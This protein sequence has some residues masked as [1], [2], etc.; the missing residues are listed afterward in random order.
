MPVP[1]SNISPPEG[2]SSYSLLTIPA[3]CSD[4]PPKLNQL[5]AFATPASFPISEELDTDSSPNA[6]PSGACS[7]KLPLRFLEHHPHQ[8]H[9][10]QPA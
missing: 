7:A 5:K 8:H 2:V 9:R 4:P 3:A 1:I 6:D 10:P